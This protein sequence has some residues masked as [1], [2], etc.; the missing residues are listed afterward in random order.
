M[1]TF[2]NVTLRRGKKLLLEQ[3]AAAIFTQQKV[4]LIGINGC[5]KSSLF[6]LILQKILPDGGDIY[7]QSNIRIAYLAQEVPSTEI[8]ALQYVMNGD[9]EVTALIQQLKKAEAD[10][11]GDLVTALHNRIYE[12]NGYTL[13]PRAAKLLVGLGFSLDQQQ[14][15]VNAFSSG[16]R[17]RLNLAQVLMSRAE[18]L[19]LDEP[20]NYLDLDAIVW[21]ERWLQSYEGTLLLISH[22]RD[23]L[24]NVVQ[25]IIYI[26]NCKLATYSGNYSSFERQRAARLAGERSLFEKQQLKI[27]HLNQYINRFRAKASKARQAQ[28]RIKMLEKMEKVSITQSNS[29]FSFKF[30][31]PQSC[32]A[33]LIQI[34]QAEVSYGKHTILG[35]INFS[36]N[37]QAAIGILGINGAGKSTFMKTLAG[38]LQASSGEVIFNQGLKI[39]YFAQH[40]L[41]QLEV[42]ASP[43]EHILKLDPQVGDQQIRSFLGG[44][45]FQGEMVFQPIKDFSGGEKARLVLSLLIWQ[46]PNLLLLDEPT[47]HLDLEMRA[48]LTY[49]LQDYAGALVIVAHDRYLLKATVDEF[50][51][52][53]DYQVTKFDGDLDDYQK[54]LVT[55]RK[56]QVTSYHTKKKEARHIE[57]PK[58]SKKPSKTGP[59]QLRLLKIEIS[60]FHTEKEQLALTLSDQEIYQPENRLKLE[61]CLK[62]TATLDKQ[63]KILEGNWLELQE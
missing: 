27:E 52:V 36:L 37:P 47:N 56:P 29:P 30:Y 42:Q 57:P 39:G 14:Q 49:A 1:I 8:S 35:A 53:N 4:G 5:G 62:K 26:S 13:E 32:S 15:A 16:W 17:M 6:S 33:P 43:L 24:D 9:P 40:Q 55:T 46:K 25:K 11:D 54:W 59:K 10:H 19:L 2:Q 44:F 7:V 12:V 60:K 34:N 28:S 58:N 41:D 38:I 45:G 63:I 18:L 3:A 31:Q 50:Y 23:F 21:L 51:L 61:H 22:D 48:A 20:T